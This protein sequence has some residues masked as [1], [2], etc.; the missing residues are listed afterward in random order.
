MCYGNYERRVSTDFLNQ[1]PY[2]RLHHFRL[3]QEGL[4]AGADCQVSVS[5]HWKVFEIA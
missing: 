1:F 3:N 2:V 4:L 5:S